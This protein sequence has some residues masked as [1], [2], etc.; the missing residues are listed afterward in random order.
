MAAR[1]SSTQ[2]APAKPKGKPAMPK[3]S[4]PTSPPLPKRPTT[5]PDPLKLRT[6]P[7]P[8]AAPATPRLWRQNLSCS[9]G[10]GREVER[11]SQGS[12]RNH[13]SRDQIWPPRPRAFASLL[14]SSTPAAMS[15]PAPAAPKGNVAADQEVEGVAARA[16]AG[17]EALRSAASLRCWQSSL[18][19]VST[20]SRAGEPA[21]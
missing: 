11:C 18:L 16:T 7:A 3:W 9:A 10:A 15:N 1:L 12:P 13:L 2:T 14:S 17:S 4:R 8:A 21:V 6:G 20:A 5:T 19:A